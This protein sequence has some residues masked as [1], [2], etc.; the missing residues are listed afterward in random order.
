[1]HPSETRSAVPALILTALLSGAGADV[2]AQAYPNRAIHIIAPFPAGG[3]YDFLSRLIGAEM[4]KTF[5]QPVIVENKAGANGNIGTEAAAK[6]A[7]DGYTLLMG[8]NSPLSLNVGLYPRLPYDPAKDFDPIS[9]V[10]TQPNLLA[11]NPKVPVRTLPE[12]IAYAMANPGKLTYASNGNGSPQHLAAE[13]LKR[14]AGIDIVHV[15]YKGAAPTAAALLAGEVSVAFNIIL[16]PL[17]HV[18]SGKLTGIAVAS[19]KRSPLAPN[20]PTMAELGYPIDID[21]WYGLVAPA[22]TPRDIVAKLNAETLRILNLPG[23]K[24]KTRGQ[25][26]ELGGSTPEEFATFIRE[27]IAKWTKAIREMGIT[28][29]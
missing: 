13:Q 14:M 26:I 8:G 12:L 20:L 18:Q 1:V 16:L 19:S 11:A 6:S 17:P 7:P 21:T 15:P 3:G 4:T 24:E 28:I 10:A 22:G 29:D 5:G 23:L 9:R 2:S 27:D 25:G